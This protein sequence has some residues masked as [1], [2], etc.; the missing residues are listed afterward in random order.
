MAQPL[1]TVAGGNPGKPTPEGASKQADESVDGGGNP[2]EMKSGIQRVGVALQVVSDEP[3][4]RGHGEQASGDDGY[5]SGWIGMGRPADNISRQDPFSG[6]EPLQELLGPLF[7][8]RYK[9]PSGGL[10]VG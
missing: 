4:Y 5:G 2:D 3:A 8:H 9:K 6:G 7:G 1:Q 10:G